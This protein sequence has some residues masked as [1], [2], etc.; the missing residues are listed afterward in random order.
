[1]TTTTLARTGELLSQ[2]AAVT[3]F[4]A[5]RTAAADDLRLEVKEL[6]ASQST[7]GW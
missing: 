1:M 5:R 6:I 2:V 7:R 4:A 3:V